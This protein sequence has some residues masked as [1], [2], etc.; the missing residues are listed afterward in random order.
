MRRICNIVTTF[1]ILT[2]LAAIPAFAVDTVKKVPT[3]DEM[4]NK[5]KWNLEDIYP[6]TAAWEA[7]FA[8]AESMLPEIDSYKGRLG[9]SGGALFE[10]LKLHEKL[11]TTV[12]QLYVYSYMKLDS[13]TRQSQ[14]QE[15]SDRIGAFDTRVVAAESFIR[16]EILAIEPSKLQGFFSETPELGDYRHYLEDIQRAREHTLSPEAEKVLASAGNIARGSNKLFT[17]LD[18]A[19]IEYGTITDED[20]NKVELTKERYYKILESENRQVR[21]EASEV[22]NGAYKNYMNTLGANLS[23]SVYADVF[24]AKSRKYGST[25]EHKLDQHNIPRSVVDNLV[26]ATNANFAPLHR[27]TSLQKKVLG[28]DTL[29]TYDTSVPLVKGVE[30]EIPWDEAVEMVKKATEPLG[31]Q[32]SADLATGFNSGWIDVYETEGKSSGAYSWGAYGTHPYVLM[33]YNGTVTATSTLAHEMGHAMHSFYSKKNQNYTNANYATFVAEV[34]S[35]VNE[36][37]LNDYLMKTILDKNQ[38]K[39]IVNKFIETTLGTYYVQVMFHE[40]EAEIHDVVENGGSLSSES[41][42]AMYREIFQKYF[43]PD[44][45]IPEGRDIGWARISHFYRAFYVYQ[46][47]TSFSAATMIASRILDGD[48]EARDAYLEML[49]SG[50]NDYPIE[51]LK[52]AGVDMT[53]PDAINSVLTLFDK[54]VGEMEELTLN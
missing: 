31:E 23:N 50:G 32:Y 39:Y 41:M 44:L 43:G 7:D 51:L 49:R 33:N 46:Y 45:Y 38:K 8:K 27:Y 48:T 34:A 36:I 6:S 1:L 3:R 18:D 40:F 16:P 30:F 4:E 20:G 10:F 25:L 53:K 11:W 54:L 29:F 2:L 24:F 14:Y 19:D 21:R 52:K 28:Y 42:T 47:A 12:D 9:E 26:A 22:Y 17:M 35:T 13:D 37:L 15:L 5:Y